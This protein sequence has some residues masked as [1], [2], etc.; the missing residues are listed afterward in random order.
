MNLVPRCGFAGAR[1]RALRLN[2]KP[3]HEGADV[4]AADINA[5]FQQLAFQ[6]PCAHERVPYVQLVNGGHTLGTTPLRKPLHRVLNEL[7]FPVR[8]LGAVHFE[9]STELR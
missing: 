1:L 2:V 4:A 7:S 6:L 9:L 3:P 8:N 5:L